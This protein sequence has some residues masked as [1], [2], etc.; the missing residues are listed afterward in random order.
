[1]YGRRAG[2]I[3]TGSLV[4][5]CEL[6]SRLKRVCGCIWLVLTFHGGPASMRN[7][8]LPC[9]M[10]GGFQGV[11]A[12]RCASFALAGLGRT[13]TVTRCAH[14][15]CGA[16][17][18]GRWGCPSATMTQLCKWQAQAHPTKPSHAMPAM[19]CLGLAWQGKGAGLCVG[20]DATSKGATSLSD[21]C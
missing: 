20:K 21:M 18:M 7:E 19:P 17:G 1:M 8:H 4:A 6:L 5:M 16:D 12:R 15:R 13:K 3:E 10:I 2:I 9:V 14:C 11:D